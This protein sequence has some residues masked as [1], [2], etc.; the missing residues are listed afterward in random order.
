MRITGL[1]ALF[2]ASI[3]P[4]SILA[5]STVVGDTRVWAAPDHTRIVFDISGPIQ[6]KLFSLSKP[7]RIVIDLRDASLNISLTGSKYNK[8]I[9]KKI[10]SASRNQKD[11]RI[12]LDISKSVKTKSF[13]LKPG[14]N[15]NHRLVIDLFDKDANSKNAKNKSAKKKLEKRVNNSRELVIAIDAGHGGDD[16]GAIGYRGTREKDVVFAIAKKLERLVSKAAGMRP[17][18]IRKGDYYVSLRKRIKK[19]RNSKADMFISIHADAF[20]D[21]RAKGASVYALS[22][23]GASTEAANWL[24]QS[25]N[26][27][28]FVG[29][30]SLEDKDELLT[31]V[32]LDLSMSGT[33]EASME[34]GNYVLNGL[35]KVGKVHKKRVEQAEFA[36]LKSPDTPSIL[37]ETAFISNPQEEQNLLNRNHQQK[38]ARSIM[39]GI[40]IYFAK[41]P[42]PGTILAGRKHTIVRGETLSG[43]AS[44]Y[45]VSLD[46]LKVANHMKSNHLK[47]GGVLRIPSGNGG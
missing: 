20:R 25:E 26:A 4:G 39:D 6:H 40:Q 22:Q 8:G 41:N 31:S 11:L 30:V 43:I 42:V 27:S 12:V 18:M 33:I 15:Y 32:L 1:I 38:V 7:D 5:Q 29:G 44:R 2:V 37:I 47:V 23:K 36:V 10:R 28:D 19:A 34:M 21:K 16:P 17:L 24:A 45:D 35:K 14:Q 13:V 46:L 9:I 3:L